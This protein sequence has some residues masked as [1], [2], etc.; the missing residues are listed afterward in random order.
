M[1]S[2]N[3][4]YTKWFSVKDLFE[5]GHCRRQHVS[6]YLRGSKNPFISTGLREV[7]Y[8][9]SRQCTLMPPGISFELF[10]VASVREI[11]K[12]SFQSG[13]ILFLRKIRC[14]LVRGETDNYCP[15]KCHRLKEVCCKNQ[16]TPLEEGHHEHLKCSAN[17]P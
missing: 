3:Y 14:P 6:R 15:D 9:L 11:R 17:S 10:I 1:F 7:V 4:S 8:L 12:W 16:V 5:T 2:I 13:H